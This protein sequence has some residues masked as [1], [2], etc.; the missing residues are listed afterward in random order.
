MFSATIANADILY[1]SE[2]GCDGDDSGSSMVYC[3]PITA[4]EAQS[5]NFAVLTGDTVCF[6]GTFTSSIQP[7]EGGTEGSETVLDGS[8]SGDCADAEEAILEVVDQGYGIITPNAGISHLIIKGFTIT[9]TDT[10]IDGV[11]IYIRGPDSGAAANVEI[12]E[13]DI[14]LYGSSDT[15]R[16][17]GIFLDGAYNKFW[18]HGNTVI[19]LNEYA[20]EGIYLVQIANEGDSI[21]IRAYDN[22]VSDWFHGCIT[23]SLISSGD[24]G[25]VTGAHIYGNTISSKFWGSLST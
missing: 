25:S 13:N 1:V 8:G 16:T 5:G 19:G 20:F 7:D 22:V 18:V 17:M 3:A 9:N 10:G 23:I 6:S 24:A 11:G 15:W 12:M 14:Q 21:D 4:Y 2:V